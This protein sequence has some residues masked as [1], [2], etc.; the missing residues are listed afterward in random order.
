MLNQTQI[1]VVAGTAQ[2]VEHLIEK[3]RCNANGRL[4]PQ[5]GKE[6]FSQSQLSVQTLFTVSAE[7][8]GAIPC[9]NIC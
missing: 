3:N 9:I 6:F 1:F 2:L 5:C 4:S 7:P 8:P